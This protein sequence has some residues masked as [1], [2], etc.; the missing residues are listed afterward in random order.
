MSH[1][2]ETHAAGKVSAKYSNGKGGPPTSRA[3]LH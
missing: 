1:Q 3:K 2:W